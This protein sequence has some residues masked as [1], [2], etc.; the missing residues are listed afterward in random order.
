MRYSSHVK[1][2]KGATNREKE[3]LCSNDSGNSRRHLLRNGHVH[4]PS[5]GMEFLQTRYHYGMYRLCSPPDNAWGLAENGEQSAHP[6]LREISVYGA[7]GNR[8]RAYAGWRY[9]P[10]H[11]MGQNGHRD[12]G[13]PCGHHP[14]SFFDSAHSGDQVT[15]W[16]K[17]EKRMRYSYKCLAGIFALGLGVAGWIFISIGTGIALLWDL[18]MIGL[19]VA[20]AGLIFLLMQIPFVRLLKQP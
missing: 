13:W 9:E 16:W 19:P 2:M 7:S 15:L 18:L 11:G 12:S 3:Q 10:D 5:A 14:A 17:G 6:V 4:V 8:R 20:F 1:R